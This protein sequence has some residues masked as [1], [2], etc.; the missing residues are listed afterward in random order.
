MKNQQP[1]TTTVKASIVAPTLSHSP[2][3]YVRLY[4]RQGVSY[5]HMHAYPRTGV[6]RYGEKTTM[7]TRRVDRDDKTRRYW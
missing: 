6:P 1:P 2:A 5:A 4:S 3:E 7:S